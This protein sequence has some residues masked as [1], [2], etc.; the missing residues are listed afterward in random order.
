MG[1]SATYARVPRQAILT[2]ICSAGRGNGCGR[3]SERAPPAANRWS[4]SACPLLFSGGANGKTSSRSSELIAKGGIRSR[5][6]SRTA[7]LPVRQI[8]V[9]YRSKKQIVA[10]IRMP[11]A[12][13]SARLEARISAEL[14]ALL[15]RAA[16]IQGRT[17]TDFLV[18]A[19]QDAAERAIEQAGA[20]RLSMADQ[21]RFARALLSPP[22]PA[23][24]LKRAVARRRR[25]VRSG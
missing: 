25:L 22:K 1:M 2:S 17:M 19:V 13:A 7:G 10:G 4:I 12:T 3:R 15:K 14:H 16:E 24:A 21:E 8:A 9:N 23:A 6:A 18:S 20:V 5:K 11:T